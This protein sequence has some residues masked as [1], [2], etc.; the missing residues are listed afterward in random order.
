MESRVRDQIQ[1]RFISS[2]QDN[3]RRLTALHHRIMAGFFCFKSFDRWDIKMHLI[4]KRWLFQ[5][6]KLNVYS[7]LY[8]FTVF[9]TSKVKK[10][11]SALNFN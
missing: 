2:H 1:H 11:P 7:V 9:Y 10:Y 4:K 6:K 3:R 8:Y 5:V